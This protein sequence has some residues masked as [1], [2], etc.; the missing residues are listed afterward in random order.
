MGMSLIRQLWSLLF[1]VIGLAVAGAVAVNG[2]S[3]RD[4]LADQVRLKNA[5]NAQALALVLSQQRGEPALIETLVR[6][7]ADTG[8]YQRIRF[9]DNDGRS[10]EQ[11]F[12]VRPS[13]APRWLRA[14]LPIESRPGRAAVSDGW[15]AI[16]EVEV[17]THVEHA[18][19]ALWRG[20]LRSLGWLLVVALAA[21]AAAWFGVQRLGRP[22]ADTVAQAA[23][24]A[25][26]RYVTVPE[27]RIPELR[28]VSATMNTMVQ[29][30]RGLIEAEAERAEQWRRRAHCDALTGLP[31]R[32]HFVDRLAALAAREDVPGAGALALVR[33]ATL[34]A[35][36]RRLGRERV[37]AALRAIAG[38]LQ[39]EAEG[40][41]GGAG[42]QAGEALA[43]RL[44]GSDFAFFC[45]Q[46]EG[47]RERAAAL[48]PA[49]REALTQADVAVHL[50]AVALPARWS[51]SML[52]AQADLALAQAEAAAPFEAGFFEAGPAAAAL[53]AGG[54]QAWGVQ[55]RAALEA[56]RTAIAEFPVL[57][58]GRRL[59]HLECPLRVV[60]NEGGSSE[61]AARWLPL[62]LRT[63]LTA[64]LDAE[65]L[66]L[67]L[68]AIAADGRPR[69]VNLAGA[70][71]ADADFVDGLREQLRHNPALA[72]AL[73]IELPE[74]A[75]LE[76]PRR[77]MA[78]M[79]L[80]R[81]LGVH[82]GLEHAGARLKRLSALADLG[83]DY[84]K[85]DAAFTRGLAGNDAAQEFVRGL[86]RL[87]SGLGAGALAEGVA[88]ADDAAA[89]FACGVAGVTGPWAAG[90]P[91]ASA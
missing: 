52:L 26:G 45:A 80:M 49:L 68:A 85:I 76:H 25:E 23:A 35:Q 72:R 88:G 69:C 31:H 40:G 10:V 38:V 57:D 89:L 15:R 22:L 30:V 65:A 74:A 87:L 29:R 39:A 13:D 63:Q 5:D 66:R 37:D 47:G 21:A 12:D 33:V 28:R 36:N 48:G 67:A 90:V 7:Q 61:P 59:L 42:G 82:L 71:L 73:W 20:V 2:V 70:S 55:L 14:L 41:A 17:V 19:T 18:Y 9:A 56:G 83:L 64:S 60:L 32:A 81:P 53:P 46:D 8:H 44:N 4:A 16:G 84:V 51:P 77:V 78:F 24:L 6:A 58:A 54:E 62:A 34:D 91:R 11:R 1:V 75:A 43:A 50:G 79:H 3:A 27:P 86:V